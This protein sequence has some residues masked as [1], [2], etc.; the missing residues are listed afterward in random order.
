MLDRYE[1]TKED[2][3]S[4][5]ITIALITIFGLLLFLGAEAINAAEKDTFLDNET[6]QIDEDGSDQDSMY[7]EDDPVYDEMDDYEDKEDG[8][9]DR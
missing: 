9:G 3:R 7:D 8:E 6:I 2:V 5:L 1:R 4:E